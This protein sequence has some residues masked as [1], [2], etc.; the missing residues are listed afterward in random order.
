MTSIEWPWE[1]LPPG[2]YFD[3]PFSEYL[4]QRCVNASGIK[5]ILISETTFWC[6]SW[7]NPLK[8]DNDTDAKRDG[9][10]Y[11]T[12]I[13]EGKEAFDA[14]YAEKYEDDGDPDMLRTADDIKEALKQNG[15]A[16]TFKKKIDGAR[17]LLDADPSIRILD[18]EKHDFELENEDKELLDAKTIRYMELMARIIAYHPEMKSWLVG[19]YPEVTVI[20]DDPELKVRCKARIDYMKIA[21]IVDLKTFANQLGKS[22][23]KAIER[24]I[25]NHRYHIP[26]MFY[27]RSMRH[28]KNLV[29]AGHVFNTDNVDPEWLKQFASTPCEDFWFIFAL[30]G[31]APVARGAKWST[32]DIKFTSSAGQI[33]EEGCER[34]LRAYNTF[35]E[36]TWLDINRAINLS[37]E[38]LPS[39]ITDV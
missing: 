33:I 8:E 19:G 1:T 15:A 13:L 9:R 38:S 37:Y 30:K 28:A 2:V 34:F 29:S 11:H 7:M 21:Q 17:R 14:I 27:L 31:V 3:L 16:V 20:W 22:I 18:I 25:A 26:A 32:S 6:N 5:D 24:E 10:A 4:K 39:Y 23:D 12:R 35:G 36:D